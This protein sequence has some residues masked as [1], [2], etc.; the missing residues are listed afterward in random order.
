MPISVLLVRGVLAELQRRGIDPDD[1]LRASGL[2]RERVMDIHEYLLFDQLDRLVSLAIE[3][4]NDPGLGL[5]IGAHAPEAMLQVFGH[6][7]VAHRT[8]REA[9]ASWERYSVMLSDATRFRLLERDDVALFLCV[10]PRVTAR[11]P[12]FMDLVLAL[13]ARL[14]THFAPNGAALREVH[15]HH[16]T[17]S[18]AALYPEVFGCPVLFGQEHN[19][20]IFPRELLDRPQNHADETVRGF[21]L[22][23]VERLMQER[24][25][26]RT[27]TQRVQILLQSVG[28][29]FARA[30]AEAIARQLGMSPRTL[31]RRLSS[32][33]TTFATLLDEARCRIACQA[34]GVAGARPDKVAEILRFSEPSAFRRAFKRWTGLTPAEYARNAATERVASAAAGAST[35]EEGAASPS[36]AGPADERA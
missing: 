26:A 21:M 10:P 18:Y 35:A 7:M 3:R 24:N 36:R 17:P 12:F 23:A 22:E 20:L 33:G 19:A 1:L 25:R 15:F 5:A 32:E 8:M 2:T 11:T 16:A 34:L 4:T 27:L 6:F 30:E 14:G 29:D 28:E 31:R 13:S 9:M